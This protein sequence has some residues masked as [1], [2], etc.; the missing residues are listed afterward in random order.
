MEDV[1]KSQ[2]LIITIY[3]GHAYSNFRDNT[4][5]KL[6]TKGQKYFDDHA[7]TPSQALENIS[8]KVLF[9]MLSKGPSSYEGETEI[10]KLKKAWSI[11]IGHEQT[12]LAMTITPKFLLSLVRLGA[13]PHVKDKKFSDWVRNYKLELSLAISSI[14]GSKDLPEGTDIYKVV[15]E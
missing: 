15:F 2:K 3:V 10:S 7:N 1:T 11:T 12:R 14:E 13:A 5:E 6:A 8:L 4:L 9:E